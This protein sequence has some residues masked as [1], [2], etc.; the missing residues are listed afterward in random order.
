VRV[1]RGVWFL[2]IAA[3]AAV[4]LADSAGVAV[5]Q[6]AAPRFAE[7]FEVTVNRL[8]RIEI[9]DVGTIAASRP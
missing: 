1:R 2:L 4:P 5:G 3:P 7:S 8:T 9:R 6:S